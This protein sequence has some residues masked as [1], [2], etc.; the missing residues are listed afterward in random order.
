MTKKHFEA[1]AEAFKEVRAIQNVQESAEAKA[2]LDILAATL[3][4]ICAE[5]NGR[6]DKNRFLRACGV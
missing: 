5:S 6:F 4:R 1:I 3:S 2:A